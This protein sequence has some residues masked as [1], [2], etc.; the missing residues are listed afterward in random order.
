MDKDIQK[1]LITMNYISIY[2]LHILTLIALG[3][4]KLDIKKLSIL[5]GDMKENLLEPANEILMKYS[6]AKE[7][8]K[9]RKLK[10]FTEAVG[11][12]KI[13]IT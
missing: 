10:K 7:R 1:D 12:G 8:A 4:A 2:Y 13:Y 9:L 11:K 3:N 6:D 5:L